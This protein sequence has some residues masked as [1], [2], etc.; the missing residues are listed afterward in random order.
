VLCLIAE[1]DLVHEAVA[2]PS[3]VI[4]RP[5]HWVTACGRGLL[6]VERG[7]VQN[8]TGCSTCLPDFAHPLGAVWA[9]CERM[10]RNANAGAARGPAK[11]LERAS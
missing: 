3:R 7:P 6:S 5:D 4:G 11:F 10:D 9:T 8:G 2:Y 1:D